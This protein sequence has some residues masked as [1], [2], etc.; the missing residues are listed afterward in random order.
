MLCSDTSEVILVGGIERRRWETGGAIAVVEVVGVQGAWENGKQ[1]WFN[2][3]GR[4]AMTY[5]KTQN[6]VELAF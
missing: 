6:R 3:G 1:S 4:V 2:L 5:A